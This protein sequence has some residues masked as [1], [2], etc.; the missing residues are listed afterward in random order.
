MLAL[1][2]AALGALDVIA[3]RGQETCDEVRMWLQAASRWSESGRAPSE[4][5]QRTRSLRSFAARAAADGS[6]GTAAGRMAVACEEIR[7]QMAR[8][9]ARPIP[10]LRLCRVAVMACVPWDE[11]EVRRMVSG[12]FWAAIDGNRGVVPGSAGRCDA[13]GGAE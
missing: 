6:S 8:R 12:W 11:R 3:E 5:G 7:R 10:A 2:A 4:M 13:A 9:E 1:C